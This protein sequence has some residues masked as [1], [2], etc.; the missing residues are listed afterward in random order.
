MAGEMES[1][2][3][4]PSYRADSLGGVTDGPTE[5]LYLP[6]VLALGL[7]GAKLDFSVPRSTLKQAVLLSTSVDDRSDDLSFPVPDT[8]SAEPLETGVF[9]SRFM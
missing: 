6:P 2:C 3:G 4:E 9:V 1:L 8:G 7:R 5:R